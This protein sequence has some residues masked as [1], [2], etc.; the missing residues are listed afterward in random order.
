MLPCAVA[1]YGL[2]D[3]TD[4]RKKGQRPG[5]DDGDGVKELDGGDERSRGEIEE[6]DGTDVGTKSGVAETADEAKDEGYEGHDAS[7]DGGETV[8]MEHGVPDG[9]DETDTLKGIDG[10]A[11]EDGIIGRVDDPGDVRTRGDVVENAA[12]WRVLG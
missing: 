12:V 3:D 1:E 8:R 6:S 7:E 5:E 2:L 11:N 4:S 9:N 10:R